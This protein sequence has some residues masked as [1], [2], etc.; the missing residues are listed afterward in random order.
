MSDPFT[1]RWGILATG[2]I[3]KTFSKDLLI[4]P[5]TRN[6]DVRHRVVAAASSTSASRA[7]EFLRDIGAEAS[8][9]AYGSYKELAADPDVDII[10]I[11]TPHSH[12]YQNAR[13]CLEANKNVLVEKAFTTNAQQAEELIKI[14]RTKNVFMME[15]LW[16]RYFPLSIYVR[17]MITSGRLGK[18]HSAHANIFILALTD[19]KLFDE[20]SR[21]V[22]PE[23]AGGALL[24][25][26]IYAL[27]WI[28]QCLYHTL[29]DS[30]KTQPQV[31][32][33]VKKY[34]LS[35][36]D[37]MT[38]MVLSFPRSAKL[39]GDIHAVAA[40]GMRIS[41]DVDG[42]GTSGPAVRIRGDKGE[43]QVRTLS[44]GRRSFS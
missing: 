14:A 11:A 28:F 38:S 17:E 21:M 33:I 13:L 3:A 15:A 30:E 40:T 36:V 12:H 6:V 9:K 24:D 8:A 37:E 10:Y 29:P 41:N 34:P 1:L 43:I 5:K 27:T 7:E 31:A 2:G 44:T 39:G 32:S 16:T 26:G 19:E 23:L 25:L 18:V 35:G 42:K 22:N 4:D 20:S